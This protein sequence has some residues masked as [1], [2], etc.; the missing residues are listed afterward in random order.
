MSCLPCSLRVSQSLTTRPTA[1]SSPYLP[2]PKSHC[3]SVQLTP[4][5]QPCW[6]LKEVHRTISL[7]HSLS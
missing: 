3:W 6:T 1:W 7:E 2:G 5:R 4:F